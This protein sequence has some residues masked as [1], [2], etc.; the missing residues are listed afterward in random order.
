MAVPSVVQV[1]AIGQVVAS[2]LP[3]GQLTSHLHESLHITAAHAFVA[4]HFTLQAPSPH[5]MPPHALFVEHV[6]SHDPAA[7]QLIESHAPPAEHVIA[8]LKPWG[9]TT[10]LHLFGLLQTI[11]QLIVAKLQSGQM[12]GQVGV[13][14]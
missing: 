4:V 8:Q 1:S 9:Q 13:M 2:Q 3:D 12:A 6:M 11:G 5:W 7:V 10:V 14:Q